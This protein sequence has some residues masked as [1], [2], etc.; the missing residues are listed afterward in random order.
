MATRLRTVGWCGRLVSVVQR[1]FVGGSPVVQTGEVAALAPAR[2]IPH[3]GVVVHFF[4]CPAGRTAMAVF[5]I[6]ACTT[7]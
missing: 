6:H 4:C 1:H 2:T 7:G 5:A 3:R